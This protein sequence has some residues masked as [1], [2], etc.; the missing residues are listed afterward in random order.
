MLEHPVYLRIPTENEQPFF[1]NPSCAEVVIGAV[2]KA[3]HSGWMRLHG[4]VILPETL[5][6]VA[7]PLKLSVSALVG[8]LQSETIPLLTIL[9]PNAGL[10][11]NRYFMRT[12]L[13]SQRSLDARLSILLLSPVAA[14]LAES[15]EAY[16]FSSANA[17]YSGTISVFAGFQNGNAEVHPPEAAPT[18]EQVVAQTAPTPPDP[19]L[20]AADS[21]TATKEIPAA[22]SE[23]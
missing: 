2:M 10:I 4:F 15:A 19:E 9:I 22:K 12:P 20:S 18:I 16:G 14:G 17:R 5:E 6:L 11:W 23:V 3:Q 21:V 13:E 8:H 7:T 1:Q